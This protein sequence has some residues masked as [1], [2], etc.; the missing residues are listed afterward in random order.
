MKPFAASVAA[1]GKSGGG[2]W[3]EGD[4]L[5]LADLGKTLRA[6]ADGG[7]DA[8]Y[9]GPIADQIAADMHANGGLISKE[10]LAAYQ[11]KERTPLK[12]TYRGYEII[13]MP[14]P[15]SGGVALIEMLNIL[16]TVRSEV[17]G[18]ADRSGI[19]P[20][21]R[22]DAARVSR[23]RAAPGR[24]GFRRRAGCP[25]HVEG[26]REDRGRDDRSRQGIEQRCELGKDIVT[27]LAPPSRTRRRISR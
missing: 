15:S 2:A 8:F 18:A 20:A 1:Y 25:A 6:I 23:S 7:A 14:P 27:T 17:E 16:E 9:K 12:G 5:V 3:N 10:D 22:S 19:A 24:S 26:V 13:S 11:A 21:D 4:R